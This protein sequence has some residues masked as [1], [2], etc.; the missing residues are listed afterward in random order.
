MRIIRMNRMDPQPHGHAYFATPD[1][2]GD[3]AVLDMEILLLDPL[4]FNPS[5]RPVKASPALNTHH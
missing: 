4:T 1:W 3:S 2:C 5:R